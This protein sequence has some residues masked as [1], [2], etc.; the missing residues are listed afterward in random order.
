MT[1]YY[2]LGQTYEPDL[3]MPLIG[4][5]NSAF[6]YGES[7]ITTFVLL[8]GKA[9]N[10]AKHY[11]RLAN[12]L[13]A[14]YELKM[15]FLL[16]ELVEI[17]EG[18]VGTKKVKIMLYFETDEIAEQRKQGELR[19]LL[20]IDEHVINLSPTPIAVQS[21]Q[22]FSGDHFGEQFQATKM[23][24][25]GREIAFRQMAM[26]KGKY[27]DILWI[28]KA[29][30]P[31]ELSTSSIFGLQM[32]NGE[33]RWSSPANNEVILNGIL[34]ENFCRYLNESGVKLDFGISSDCLVWSMNSALKFQQL[35]KIDQRV[36]KWNQNEI[37][38]LEE[39]INDFF[40]WNCKN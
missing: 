5:N 24:S 12:S 13:W 20:K 35:V 1:K 21:I 3:L 16:E 4:P 22:R 29:G 26:R 30:R 34:A 36:I 31:I 18:L 14:I 17:L 19:W 37:E 38:Y 40:I 32:I 15:P 2:Y 11:G 10:L 7:L 6:L 25:Y 27:N 9:I 8:E 39:T 23:G 28:N 33:V